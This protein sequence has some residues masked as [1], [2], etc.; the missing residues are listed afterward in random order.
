M[1]LLHW[2]QTTSAQGPSLKNGRK[3]N[4]A[5][6]DWTLRLLEFYGFFLPFNRPTLD[7]QELTKSLNSPQEDEQCYAAYVRSMGMGDKWEGQLPGWY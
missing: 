1:D 2:V 6:V 3:G 5:S 7:E 4:W